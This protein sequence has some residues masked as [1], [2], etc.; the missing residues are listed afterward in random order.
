MPAGEH[1][2]HQWVRP[3]RH[4]WII[5]C[6][7]TL[8]G[9][10][11]SQLVSFHPCFFSCYQPVGGFT[12]TLLYAYSVYTHD[13]ICSSQTW[14]IQTSTSILNKRPIWSYPLSGRRLFGDLLAL[15]FYFIRFLLRVIWFLALYRGNACNYWK[16]C[17]YSRVKGSRW[18]K[19]WTGNSP[20]APC[21]EIW[22]TFCLWKPES[23]AQK[24]SGILLKIGARNL[25]ALS[26]SQH[27]PAGPQP[28][29]SF[30]QWKMRVFVGTPSPSYMLFRIWLDSFA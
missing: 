21:S 26:K 30:W 24:K 15:F 19:N 1:A 4:D 14:K 22:E 5:P 13:H 12:E 18:I 25:R 7:A 9:V 27:W 11:H 28:D 29:Q 20:R 23:W 8:E 2:V 16:H 6:S 17:E 3:V 10:V